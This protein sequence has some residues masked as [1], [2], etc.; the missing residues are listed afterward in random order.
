MSY[1]IAS[2]VMACVMATA[3]VAHAQELRCTQV[4]MN[5]S[6]KRICASP[7][8]MQLDQQMGE[9]GRRVEPHQDSLKSDQKRFRKALKTCDGEEA[10]L[11]NSY[12]NRI[13]ELQSMI[14][15]LAP[16]TSEE[17][18][19]LDI[20]A[21]KAE[22]KRESQTDTRERIAHELTQ[23]DADAQLTHVEPEVIEWPA[24]E[25]VA[26]PEAAPEEPLSDRAPPASGPLDDGEISWGVWG[27]IALFAI[28]IIGWIQDWAHKAFRHR[29]PKCKNWNTG[30][31]FDRDSNSYTDYETK[32]FDDVHKDSHGM[33]TGSTSSTRQ[34][35]V[36][37]TD[38]VNHLRC[39][40]CSKEWTIASQS[41]SS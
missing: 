24:P 29:C 11:T 18:A 34:V 12:Q 35:A 4:F 25:P 8:L 13:A 17:I 16:P 26:I 3:G 28:G 15:T 31:V 41:R 37:V 27:L 39:K 10:C 33:T 2:I 36:R 5:P 6:E 22:E 21:A 32:T 14:A 38:T 7:E 1:R 23:K 40:I 9:L 20:G 19:A 30:T